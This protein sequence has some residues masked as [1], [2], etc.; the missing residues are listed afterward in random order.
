MASRVEDNGSGVKD[1]SL[2]TESR[3]DKKQEQPREKGIQKELTVEML[4]FRQIQMKAGCPAHNTNTYI[5]VCAF[6]GYTHTNTCVLVQIL[7]YVYTRLCVGLHLCVFCFV[8][9][10]Y[11]HLFCPCQGVE[12]RVSRKIC[13][14][15]FV[16]SLAQFLMF[17]LSSNISMCKTCL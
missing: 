17:C 10:P 12:E 2:H 7:Q 13:M 4:K 11:K 14:F 15:R 3:G 9:N 16:F 1:H 5:Y 8:F 6:H